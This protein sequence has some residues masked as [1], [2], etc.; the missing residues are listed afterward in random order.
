MCQIALKYILLKEL[1][2]KTP[3]NTDKSHGTEN[4]LQKS[5][6]SYK[7]TKILNYLMLLQKL[8]HPFLLSLL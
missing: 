7:V 8:I 5:Y 3:V 4:S 1:Y 2:N 6:K